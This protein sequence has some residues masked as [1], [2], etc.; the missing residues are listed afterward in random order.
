MRVDVWSVE[1]PTFV[2]VGTYR[3][4]EGAQVHVLHLPRYHKLSDASRLITFAMLM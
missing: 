4:G 2:V 1:I 3:R